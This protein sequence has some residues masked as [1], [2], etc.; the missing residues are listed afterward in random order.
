MSQ[1]GNQ[2]QVEMPDYVVPH[3]PP[4]APEPEPAKLGPWQRLIGTLFSPGETFQDVNRKPTWLI[5]MLLIMVLAAAFMIFFNSQTDEGWRIFM[6][7][8]MSRQ[9]GGGAQ[10]NAGN[11]DMGIKIMKWSYVGGAFIVSPIYY[12]IIAGAF[13]LVMLIMQAQT[14]FKRI[15]SVVV[16]SACGTGIVQSIVNI[17]SLLARDS[18][19]LSRIGPKELGTISAT[20]LAVVLPSGSSPALLALGQSLDI[21][22]IWFLILLVIGFTAIAGSRKITKGKIAGVVFGLWILT[23]VMKVGGAAMFGR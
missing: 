18:E 10:S 8:Q 22:S 17:A 5:P 4:P 13:A 3:A 23:I 9:S 7:E 2:M 1:P 11:L 14:T 15:L 20:N 12:L 19:S 21:F 6:R 16:W